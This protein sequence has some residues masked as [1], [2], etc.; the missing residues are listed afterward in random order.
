V[1]LD[2]QPVPET[3]NE[4]RDILNLD[5]MQEESQRISGPIDE[6]SPDED[7]R[8]AQK[9]LRSTEIPGTDHGRLLSRPSHDMLTRPRV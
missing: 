4:A 8:R 9:F 7:D 2:L 3:D 5:D 6:V 1:D